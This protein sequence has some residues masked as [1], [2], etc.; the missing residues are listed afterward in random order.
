MRKE[1]ELASP[2]QGVSRQSK[3]ITR[4]PNLDESEYD[5]VEEYNGDADMEPSGG[6]NPYSDDREFLDIQEE[7]PQSIRDALGKLH[8]ASLQSIPM[9]L[10][11]EIA[12]RSAFSPS[13]SIIPPDFSMFVARSTG[14]SR[15]QQLFVGR[16]PSCSTRIA[17]MVSDDV[18]GFIKTGWTQNHEISAMTCDGPPIPD[19]DTRAEICHLT[20]LGCTAGQIRLRLDLNI[21]G[22][23]LHNV[24]RNQLRQCRT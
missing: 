11:M 18:V 14:S 16:H 19:S 7:T 20:S 3:M 1:E 15:S 21:S 5:D 12:R 6:V 2:E 10:M 13:G 17:F 8:G 22:E 23:M 4:I 9:G 24:R